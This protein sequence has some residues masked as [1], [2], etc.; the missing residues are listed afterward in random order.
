MEGKKLR[1]FR[2]HSNRK[3]DEDQLSFVS[4]SNKFLSIAYFSPSCVIRSFCL[5]HLIFQYYINYFLLLSWELLNLYNNFKYCK[6]Y[7]NEYHH[8]SNAA[9]SF[10]S[11]LEGLFR[12][13]EIIVER[14]PSEY[15]NLR[16]GLHLV[17]LSDSNYVPTISFPLFPFDFLVE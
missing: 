10:L 11:E 6:S 16:W 4:L 14:I 15:M 17:S 5:F 7:H 1:W 9:F 12:G 3:L 8:C 13:W 2:I